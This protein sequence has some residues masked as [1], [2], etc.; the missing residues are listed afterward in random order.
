M[1]HKKPP[2]RHLENKKWIFCAIKLKTSLGNI[3][4]HAK[5][6]MCAQYGHIITNYAAIL[7]ITLVVWPE[8]HEASNM[9]AHFWEGFFEIFAIF[10][11]WYFSLQLCHIIWHHAKVLHYLDRFW[12]SYA[13]FKLWS[14]RR[15]WRFLARGWASLNLQWIS[16][17]IAYCEPKNDFSKKSWALD[18]VPVV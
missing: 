5:M 9:I 1:L 12:I 16:D 17:E 4:C 14:K 10:Q 3:V 13:R 7:A 15:A 8:S 6:H 11:V 2:F 18:H